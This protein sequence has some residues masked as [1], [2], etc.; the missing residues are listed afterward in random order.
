MTA[1]LNFGTK[2]E[3][4]HSLSFLLKSAKILPQIRFTLDEH[5][6]D[7]KPFLS[8]IHEI[9]WLDHSLIVRSSAR[10]EDSSTASLAG[11]YTSIL[12]VKGEKS[13]LEAVEA[14][15]ASFDKQ[16]QDDQIFIQPMLTDVMMSGVAFSKNPTSGAPY[17]LINYDDCSGSTNSVTSGQ[18]N[19]LKA[20]CYYRHATIPPISP[21]DKVIQL[22]KELE[23]L[24][25]NDCL[26]IEFAITQDLELYL[27]QVRPLLI[28]RVS[29]FPPEKHTTVLQ[30]IYKKI[31]ESYGPHPYLYGSRTIYG[32]MPDWNPAEIIGIRPKPLALS[33][34]KEI[35]T[36][37]IWAYQRDNYG[38]S[39]LR[40][41]PLLINFH[42]LPYIDVRVSFNSFLPAQLEP[43][44][45][46]KLV[47]YY[48]DRL[49]QYPNFHDKVEFE[50]IY[51][52]YTLDLPQRLD[53][54]KDY[55]FQEKEIEL[56][57]SHLRLLTNQ[58]I[59]AKKGLWRKDIEKI[60]ELE[61]RYETIIHSNL[62]PIAKIYWLIEDCKRYGTLPFAGLARAG[63][64][65]IQLLKSLV[66]VDIISKEEY[67]DFLSSL[68]TVSSRMTYDLAHLSKKDFLKEYGHLRPGTYDILSPRYDEAPDEYFNWEEVHKGTEKKDTHFQLS[69]SQIKKIENLLQTHGLN[70]TIIS[71]FDFIK[72]AIEGREYSKF[73]FTRSLSH[74]ISYIK[75]LAKPFGIKPEQAAFIDIA[76]IKKLYASSEDIETCLKKSIEDGKDAFISTEQII[77]PP[78]ISDPSQVFS[79]TIP[80]SD[81]NYITLK[82]AKGPLRKPHDDKSLLPGSI[83]LILSADPGYDWI[84]S[85]GIAGF[86]T[87]YGGMNS[88][89]AIRAGELGI[90]A[91]I[92][93]GETLYRSIEHA[94]VI[95][96][97]CPSRLI[98]VIQ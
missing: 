41:F 65:A 1:K 14:V 56:L 16:R 55:G 64:I 68:D 8:K 79:F 60:T 73:I 59:D 31:A 17:I 62:D 47:N 48:L 11:H 43:G 42:G 63:F 23:T 66:N 71:F 57:A 36:D 74:V 61:K 91:V 40:S 32:V 82:T 49:E 24:F 6:S 28:S 92:G 80:G 88:H 44:L 76:C 97:D 85:H 58:I 34:Y 95:E 86:I 45:A 12:G 93:T 26:D 22:I 46:D 89:M 39:N 25:Q 69:L 87:M 96:I 10:K 5:T 4:L 54:L 75:E 33:L 19:D 77:L 50:I 53:A 98:R 30:A 81:P 20:Y 72:A 3:T 84:F 9:G 15:I 94:K 67:H 35:I 83:I 13:L 2:A 18:T 52:C 37:S 51:S 78:L 7:K 90:P 21:F 38:Y 29:P 70:H 27:F